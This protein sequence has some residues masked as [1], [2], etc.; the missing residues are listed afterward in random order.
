MGSPSKSP[1]TPA[2]QDSHVSSEFKMNDLHVQVSGLTVDCHCE[3]GRQADD[4]AREF[5]L[6]TEAELCAAVEVDDDEVAC[7]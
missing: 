5:S 6:K 2:Q 1:H 3:G 4:G 7:N